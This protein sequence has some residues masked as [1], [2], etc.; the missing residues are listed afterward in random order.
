MEKMG[1]SPLAVSRLLPNTRAAV[2]MLFLIILQSKWVCVKN[3]PISATSFEQ[4]NPYNAQQ[5]AMS[6][7]L[8]LGNISVLSEALPEFSVQ[9]IEKFLGV[10]VVL[11]VLHVV[12]MH[13][14]GQILGHFAA[15]NHV[16][17]NGF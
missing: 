15:L 6:L 17:A 14:N 10:E 1:S 16:N 4:P 8:Q 12:T 9:G 2:K 13:A 3:H 5:E 7:L 11:A